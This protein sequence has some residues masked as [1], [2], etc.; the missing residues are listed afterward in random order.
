VLFKRQVLE[1]IAAGRITL[2]FRRWRRPTVKAGGRL[3]TAAGELAIEAVD[4]VAT[5]ALKATDARRAGHASLA[6]LTAD[7]ESQPAGTLYRIAFRVAG[8]DPR[9]A[10]RQRTTLPAD[11]RRDLLGRLDRMDA[12]A[13]MPWTRKA[14]K[15]IAGND[16]VRAAD[17]ARA[18]GE[19]DLTRFKAR[20]RR[21]KDLGLTESLKVGYRLS[22]RGRTVLRLKS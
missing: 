7:I 17:L 11:E 14:L 10:L 12:A 15:L 2:A 5:G 1:G 3:R 8:A 16:G 18:M 9:V 19:A 22:P 13:G 6:A 4:P 21:L 20:V